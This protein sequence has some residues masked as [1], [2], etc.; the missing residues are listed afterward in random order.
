MRTVGVGRGVFAAALI[1][2]GLFGL[3]KGDFVAIW[4]GVPRGVPARAGLAYL[5][6]F[7]SL[8]C[9]SG[10]LWP[11]ARASAA[12]VLLA[13]L[14]LWLLL[15]K[16][17]V[18]A[19]APAVEVSWEDFAETLVILAAAWVLY[20]SFVPHGESRH[21]RFASGATGVHTG[22]ALYGFALIPFGLAHF[23]YAS[24]TAALVPAWLPA[25]TAWAYLTGCAYLAAGVAVITGVQARMAAALSALQMG[26]FTALVWAP[27][28]ASGH[29][30]ASQLNETFISFALTASGWVV[31]DSWGI[32]D[33]RRAEL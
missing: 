17:R 2:T 8:G 6:A 5:C 3:F 25:H 24:E 7:V 20:A 26:L 19:R 31:A 15:V 29:A 23:A 27:T 32:Q 12:R 22:R 28:V 33:V 10:L 21:L 9:G 4:Q 11:R 18:P 16:L 14:L 30:D 13:W 1:A